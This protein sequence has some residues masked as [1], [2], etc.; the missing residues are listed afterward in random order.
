MPSSLSTSLSS[1]SSLSHCEAEQPVFSTSSSQQRFRLGRVRQSSVTLESD[2]D[3][4]PPPPVQAPGHLVYQKSQ[5]QPQEQGQKEDR[6]PGPVQHY[7]YVQN[8]TLVQRGIHGQTPSLGLNPGSTVHGVLQCQEIYQHV[9]N[10]RPRLDP[11]TGP[12]T[13]L[14]FMHDTW[15]RTRRRLL[16][17]APR[18]DMDPGPGSV[19][20]D[21]WKDDRRRGSDFKM[22]RQMDQL[23]YDVCHYMVELLRG[24][25]IFLRPLFSFVLALIILVLIA[26]GL[27]QCIEHFGSEVH[28]RLVCKYRFASFFVQCPSYQPTPTVPLSPP[29]PVPNFAGLI[30]GQASSIEMIAD[31]LGPLKFEP[32]FITK[33]WTTQSSGQHASG[34]AYE[35]AGGSKSSNKHHQQHK[36]GDR[37]S[38]DLNDD[39]PYGL[40]KYSSQGGIPL[41]ELIKRTELAVVDLKSSV[42]HSILPYDTKEM[43]V[44]KLEQYHLRAKMAA[45]QVLA[46]TSR[47]EG[48]LDGLVIKNTYL[49][50]DLRRLQRQREI[51]EA[52][53]S[54]WDRMRDKLGGEGG[55]DRGECCFLFR[56]FSRSVTLSYNVTLIH[57]LSH[58]TPPSF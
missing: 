6:G 36:D 7:Q 9:Q 32:G 18:P 54:F 23:V 31:S 57:T 43:M 51:L 1:V 50:K 52:P 16:D 8:S 13:G 14:D 47:A 17:R 39:D 19:R 28:T 24:T 38:G 20:D 21:R 35:K 3:L 48:S 42:K 49:M 12:E 10:R 4:E 27:Y 41:P 44:A 26:G 56:S 5:R 25:F 33:G 58:W 29:L 37:A 55:K 40:L 2:S 11:D 34:G 30:N 53:Q 22:G 45:R 15:P 46:L